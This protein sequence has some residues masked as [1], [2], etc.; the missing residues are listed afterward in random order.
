VSDFRAIRA[1]TTSLRSLVRDRMESPVAITIA[2]PDG[3][4]ASAAGRRL[5]IYLY[6]LSRDGHLANQDLPGRSHPGEYGR[7]PLSLELHYLLTAYGE[8]ETGADA[9]LEAQEI[10][11]DAMRVLH[12]FPVIVRELRENGGTGSRPL[13]DPAL[14]D[15]FEQ[16]KVTLA[17][18]GIE[19]L[20]KIWTALPEANLRRS[21]AYQ[22][23]AVQIESRQRR[24]AALPVRERRVAVVPTRA[25]HVSAAYREPPLQGVHTPAV[26][27]GE[28]LRIEGVGFGGP[29]ASARIG[30]VAITP[31]EARD[32]R[33]DVEVPD[34]VT[35]GVHALQVVRSIPLG[36]PEV[37]H[38]VM[39]SNAV[40]IQV[41]PTLAGITPAAGA[42]AGQT[43]TATVA[44]KVQPGQP[45][46]LLLGDHAVRA[47][48]LA[49][50]DPPADKLKF[51][52]PSAAAQR[53]PTGEHLVRVRVG[54]A[55]SRL[56]ADFAGPT[57][58]VTPS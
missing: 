39:Q 40:A 3:K 23:S 31:A 55:E 11:G 51:K 36:E 47:E 32:D 41:V 30:E 53:I 54:G 12:E 10:L 19:E 29:G 42:R 58:T 9:D 5:N 50:D 18:L 4:V 33:L 28:T 21:V 52:L 48:P 43:V 27:V 25:P 22:V 1:V 13:L 26:A 6:Q 46:D 24:A 57:Y 49:A 35:A 2:P 37:P 7:P 45:V 17:P 38:P 8:T 16:I 15:A 20:S 34:T 56:D 14:L 44:P